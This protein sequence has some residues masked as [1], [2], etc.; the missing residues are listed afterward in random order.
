M[1][2]LLR[3]RPEDVGLMKFGM[4]KVAVDAAGGKPAEEGITYAEAV[5]MPVF[6]ALIVFA[7]IM[8]GCSTLNLFIPGFA[9]NSGFSLEQASLAAAA[10]MA[11][12][13][14][15]KLMLGWINDRNCTAGLLISTIGRRG[16]GLAAIVSAPSVLWV[17]LTGSF[18]FGWCYA[19][20]TVQT[21]MLTRAP[22]W[23]PGT[24][25]AYLPRYLSP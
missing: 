21:A 22:W 23:V 6:Y 9:E 8:M 7:F 19:G 17:V 1:A 12:V 13:T 24:T 15:G 18:F 5:R 4:D 10:S 25:P 3:D 20:V 2:L 16:V 14:L 11:G